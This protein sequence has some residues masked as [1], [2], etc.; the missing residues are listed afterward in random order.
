M[1]THGTP[2]PTAQV[3]NSTDPKPVIT[4]D[5][6]R[7]FNSFVTKG[8]DKISVSELGNV[9]K[10]LSSNVPAEQLPRVMVN[11]DTDHD[12]FI[13]L[14]EFH[15]FWVADS[16]DGGSVELKDAFDL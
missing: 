9:L 15:A 11:F 14:D 7:V 10:A 1:A 3:P 6:H 13:Y 16:S 5:V 12:G 8:D 4:D 2:S